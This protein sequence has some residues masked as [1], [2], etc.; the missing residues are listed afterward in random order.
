MISYIIVKYARDVYNVLMNF[1]QACVYTIIP[2]IGA[3]QGY[4]SGKKVREHITQEA[5]EKTVAKF[6][7]DGHVDTSD[8]ND[9]LIEEQGKL[10]KLR[11]IEHALYVGMLAVATC[12]AFNENISLSIFLVSAIVGNLYSRKNYPG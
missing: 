11:K 10:Q 1:E 7:Q 6:K 8:L 12:A 5:Y 4:L 2:F 3:V 9:N